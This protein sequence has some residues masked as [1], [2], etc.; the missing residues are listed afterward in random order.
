ME[1]A[2]PA[3]KR[4]GRES[5]GGQSSSGDG[6]SG[7]KHLGCPGAK[8]PQ[9]TAEDRRRGVQQGHTRQIVLAGGRTEPSPEPA[10]GW[11]GW[12][13]GCAIQRLE[14]GQLVLGCL[15]AI[16][17]CS[18]FPLPLKKNVPCVC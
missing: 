11:G 18:G 7:G 5:V 8:E 1:P 6:L 9:W 16:A 14:P 2:S 13:R 15:D 12:D 10:A 17:I 4:A 3:V